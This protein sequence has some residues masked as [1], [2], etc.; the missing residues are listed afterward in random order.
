MDHAANRHFP[1]LTFDEYDNVEE[2]RVIKGS[3]SSAARTLGEGVRHEHEGD[4][5]PNLA[6]P[7]VIP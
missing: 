5:V 4:D 6:G 1:W 3:E 7:T 2:R